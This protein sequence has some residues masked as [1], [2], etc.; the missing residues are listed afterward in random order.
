IDPT[1]QE[2]LSLAFSL[3]SQWDR[4]VECLETALSVRPQDPVLW[5]RLGV[6]LGQAK[7]YPEAREAYVRALELR[8]GYR[9]AQDNL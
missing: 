8:P 9:R 4:A 7:A 3:A 5:N 6:A 1:L 2:G